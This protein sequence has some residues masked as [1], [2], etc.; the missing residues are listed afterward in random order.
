M[1]AGNALVF[2]EH[3]TAFHQTPQIWNKN[4][5]TAVFHTDPE[6]Y[7]NTQMLLFYSLGDWKI[8]YISSCC[9]KFSLIIVPCSWLLN[10]DQWTGSVSNQKKNYYL[11]SQHSLSE[12]ITIALIWTFDLSVNFVWDVCPK[13]LTIVDTVRSQL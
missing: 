5:H 7:F 9:F 12:L 13:F 3:R 8:L 2:L 6:E 4:S 11:G 1:S 10:S